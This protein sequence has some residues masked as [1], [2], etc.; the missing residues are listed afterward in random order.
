MSKISPNFVLKVLPSHVKEEPVAS[1]V[2]VFSR[3]VPRSVMGQLHL[4]CMARECF[5]TSLLG[6]WL[7]AGASGL[8]MGHGVGRD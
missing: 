6:L 1:S 7:W 4:F 2:F 8:L 3:A 5:P